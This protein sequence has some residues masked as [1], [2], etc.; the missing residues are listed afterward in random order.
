MNLLD[1]KRFGIK[2]QRRKVCRNQIIRDLAFRIGGR[3]VTRNYVRNCPPGLRWLWY[4]HRRATQ[5]INRANR[6]ILQL[7]REMTTIKRKM[8]R[9]ICHA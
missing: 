5:N 7:K 9:E 6:T 8:R 3:Y 1:I 4:I 2:L